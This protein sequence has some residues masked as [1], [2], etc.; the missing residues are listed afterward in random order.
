MG[1]AAVL[2]LGPEAEALA[3]R[4]EASGYQPLLVGAAATDQLPDV[5]VLAA[6][7]AAQIIPLRG[8]YGATPILL[9]L[10][11]D[12]VE[13][14][15]HCLTS[16]ADD[17]W[18]SS[19]GPSDLLVRLRLHLG[20]RRQPEPERVLQVA[21]LVLTPSRRQ[22]RR[23]PRTVPL[24]AREYQLLVFLTER[25]GQVLS[26]EAILARVWSDQQG[27]ASNVIE[28][29]V[30]YLRQKLE[31]AGERRLIHTVRGQGYSLCDGIPQ[32]P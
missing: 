30:R 18:L 9:D 23:G 20:L 32:I 1:S 22:V 4:L 11:V 2:L 8:L 14:R 26:R 29:Y 7:A 10:V 15:S 24:T 17:F 5:V 27:A 21:D 31:A 3:P 19:Q 16:G 12:S 6:G 25:A 28:V 13:A